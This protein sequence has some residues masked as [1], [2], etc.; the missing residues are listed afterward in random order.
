[1]PWK[2]TVHRPAGV[3][4]SAEV[5]RELD[6]QRPSAARGLRR[7]MAQGAGVLSGGAPLVRP[8]SGR[9]P[10]DSGDGGRPRGAASR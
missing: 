7:P 3:K 4:S 9:G 2:P 6:R 5:K 8:L 1:M 10:P